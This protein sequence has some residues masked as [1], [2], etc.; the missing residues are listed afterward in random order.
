MVELIIVI[1]LL[2]ILGAMGVQFI[3]QVFTGFIDTQNRTEIY[4]EGKT[5]LVRLEREIHIAVPNAVQVSGVG[6]SLGLIDDRGMADIFG[7]YSEA[8]PTGTNTITDYEAAAVSN[9]LISIYNT[10][11]ADFING[12]RLYSVISTSGN[13]MTL[14]GPIDPASP[15]RRYFV[16]RNKAVRFVVNGTTLSRETADV[17]SSGFVSGFSSSKP[18]AIGIEKTNTPTGGLPFFSYTPG[19]S[20]RNA[21]V[22]VHFTITRNRESIN[23]HK[24]IHIRNAP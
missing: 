24:E 15:Y 10:N 6:I 4:E 9:S 13:E 1:L 11:W 7:Q 14:D 5:A 16:V 20:T 19:S 3:S 22:V 2:S 12:N 17:D 21:L 8:D 23:F 18:L